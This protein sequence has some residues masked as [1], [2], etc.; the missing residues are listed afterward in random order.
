MICR[1]S[2]RKATWLLENGYIP[3][4]DTGK[5]TRRF[6]IRITDVIEYLTRL[7]DFPEYVLTPPG[8]FSSGIKHKS[9][10]RAEVQIDKD[11]FIKMLKKKWSS[12]PDA[13]TVDDAMQL[14]GHCKTTVSEWISKEKLFG[15]WYLNKYLILKDCLIEYIIFLLAVLSP[16][17]QTIETPG[18]SYALVRPGSYRIR[19][20]IR[21]TWESCP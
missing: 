17:A 9:K 12:F 14:T 8:I 3:C 19:H 21:H 20:K 4:E 7:E 16:I 1:I 13:L 18:Y 11:T 10:H 15:V 2:K 6:K 5:Q